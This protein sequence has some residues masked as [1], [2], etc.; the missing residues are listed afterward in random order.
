MGNRLTIPTDAT[1]GSDSI[2]SFNSSKNWILRAGSAYR[3]DGSETEAVRMS[4][5]RKPGSTPR[6]VA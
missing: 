5:T 3:S 2:L 6:S 4:S 1:P